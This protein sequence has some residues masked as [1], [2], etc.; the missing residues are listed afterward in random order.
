[1]DFSPHVR[2]LLNAATLQAQ[3]TQ[4]LNDSGYQLRH[5]ERY[6]MFRVGG[7]SNVLV[8]RVLALPRDPHDMDGLKWLA[9][10]LKV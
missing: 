5:S 1:M 7:V 6:Y 2:T 10:C 4:Y 3:Y 9:R 8:F